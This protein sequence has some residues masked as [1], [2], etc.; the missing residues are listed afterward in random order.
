MPACGAVPASLH[1]WLGLSNALASGVMLAASFGLLQVHTAHCLHPP[2]LLLPNTSGRGRTDSVL[3]NVPTIDLCQ[4][5]ATEMRR[6][7]P[8]QRCQPLLICNLLLS[9]IRLSRLFS[10]VAPPLPSSIPAVPALVPSSPPSPLLRVR[11]QAR[12]LS[13]S[14]CAVTSPVTLSRPPV[15]L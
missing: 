1:R 15:T 2:R 3:R 13:R 11:P 4:H 9:R 12:E 7:L 10:A 14:P 6:S 8:C 5:G